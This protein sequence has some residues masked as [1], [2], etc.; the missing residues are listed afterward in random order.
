MLWHGSAIDCQEGVDVCRLHTELIENDF[1][2]HTMVDE[3]VP[4]IVKI[5][6]EV[7]DYVEGA[8]DGWRFL[9]QLLQHLGSSLPGIMPSKLHGFWSNA[10]QVE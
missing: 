8:C 2:I 3:R 6:L 9:E 1:M 4:F 10:F 7:F 5:D